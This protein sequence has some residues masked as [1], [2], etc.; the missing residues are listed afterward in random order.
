MKYKNIILC[1]VFVGVLAAACRKGNTGGDQAPPPPPEKKAIVSTFAGDGTAAY[2]DGPLLSA[3]FLTPIDIAI[4]AS[5]ILYVADYNGRRIR[6]I[7][8]GQVSVLAGDGNFGTRNG[9]GDTAE[10]VDPYRIEVDAGGNVYEMDQADSRVRRIAPDGVVSTYAG[11]EVSGFKDGDVSVALFSVGMGGIAMGAQGSVY[12]DDTNNGRIRKISAAG[13]VSTFAGRETKGFLD[14]DTSIA[15]F[16]NPNA[17][18]FDQQGNMY[19]ADNGNYCIRKITTGGMVTRFTGA[20]TRGMADGAAGAAEFQYIYDMVID[21]DG[22]LFL[23]D[24]DRIRKVNPAGEVSTIAGSTT[25]Y[26]DGDGPAAQFNY[27]AGLAIDAEGNLY[28]ADAMNNRVRKIS[29]K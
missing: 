20:G 16:L 15:K 27:P 7:T 14:G 6:K 29:F 25:G 2:L 5:G 11:S 21:K 19:V 4:S 1:L 18:L 3:R 12:I 9:A 8:G 10:F 24:G 17:I 28:V 23:S 26:A 13:Q 22:N